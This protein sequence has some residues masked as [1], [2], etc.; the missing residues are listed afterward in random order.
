MQARFYFSYSVLTLSDTE[1]KGSSL[2]LRYFDS[3]QQKKKSIFL[4]VI[5]VSKA[6][7]EQELSHQPPPRKVKCL[8]LRRRGI[9]NGERERNT[10]THPQNRSILRILSLRIS[11]LK[12]TFP[13]LKIDVSLIEILSI[14]ILLLCFQSKSGPLWTIFSP[15]EPISFHGVWPGMNICPEKVQWHLLKSNYFTFHLAKRCL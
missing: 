5:A 7:A 13:P 9:W 4:I 11:S 15:K 8:E 1:K 3:Q 6:L 10:I 2:N 14:F 12:I